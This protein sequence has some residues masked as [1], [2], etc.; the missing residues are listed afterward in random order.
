MV[1]VFATIILMCICMYCRISPVSMYLTPF[2]FDHL[3]YYKPHSS[4]FSLK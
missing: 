4:D 1:L 2:C 3:L